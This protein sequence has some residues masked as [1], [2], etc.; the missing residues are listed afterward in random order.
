MEKYFNL[1]NFQFFKSFNDL[2]LILLVF[3]ILIILT[4][5]IAACFSQ[6]GRKGKGDR[7]KV[8]F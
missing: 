1:H 6:A 8:T 2:I 4:C 3:V 5:L 7:D